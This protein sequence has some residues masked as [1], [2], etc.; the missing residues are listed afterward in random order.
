MVQQIASRTS[1][2]AGFPDDIPPLQP[3]KDAGWRWGGG[4]DRDQI[5][6][7][8]GKLPKQSMEQITRR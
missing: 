4:G 8:K 7:P 5:P 2:H 3:S 6:A 1:G